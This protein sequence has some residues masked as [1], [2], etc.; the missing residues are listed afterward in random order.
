MAAIQFR[1]TPAKI[2]KFCVKQNSLLRMTVKTKLKL[3]DWFESYGPMKYPLG[4]PRGQPSCAYYPA[5][6]FMSKSTCVSCLE[7]CDFQ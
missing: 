2:Y 3:D 4:R 1:G 7:V 6:T 5:C